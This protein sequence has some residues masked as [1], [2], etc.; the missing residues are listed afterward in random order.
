MDKTEEKSMILNWMESCISLIQL[1][2]EYYKE[3]SRF[4]K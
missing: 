4:E 1:C 2:H 3:V